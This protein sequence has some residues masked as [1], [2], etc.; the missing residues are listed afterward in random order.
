MLYNTN[1]TVSTKVLHAAKQSLGALI[2]ETAEIVGAFTYLRQI[3]SEVEMPLDSQIMKDCE[4]MFVTINR[5]LYEQESKLKHRQMMQI[6]ERKGIARLRR[7]KDQIMRK[8]LEPAQE[9]TLFNH[10]V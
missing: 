3:A 6:A 4:Q 9:S 8:T 1:E 5:L 2:N 10:A 7:Q